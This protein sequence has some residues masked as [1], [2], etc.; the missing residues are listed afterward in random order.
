[1]KESQAWRIL[2]EEHDAGRTKS[3]FLCV[4][5]QYANSD[6]PWENEKVATIPFALRQQMITEI[7]ANIPN[8]GAAYRDFEPDTRNARTLACLMFAEQAIDLEKEA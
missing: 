2:A 7:H 6:L 8:G 4:N 1:M 3:D 5:L